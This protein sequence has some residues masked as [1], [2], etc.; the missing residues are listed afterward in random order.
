[1]KIINIGELKA[2]NLELA[3]D[4]RYKTRAMFEEAFAQGYAAIELHKTSDA[5]VYYYLLVQK[6]T[7]KI[8]Q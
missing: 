7:L 2:E 5:A 4:W 1:M 3:L 6:N 8:P